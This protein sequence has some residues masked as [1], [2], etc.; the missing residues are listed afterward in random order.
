M[1]NFNHNNYEKMFFGN[2]NLGI[3]KNIDR[4]KNIPLNDGTG[5]GSQSLP[6]DS[7]YQPVPIIPKNMDRIKNMQ[8]NENNAGS[9]SLVTDSHFLP[10]NADQLKSSP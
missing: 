8:L 3:P 9:Q 6:T 4:I 1:T 10:V 7:A 2:Q 5:A